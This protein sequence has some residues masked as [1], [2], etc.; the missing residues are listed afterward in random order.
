[1]YRIGDIVNNIIVVTLY[2]DRWYLDLMWE[3]F[4][5]YENIKSPWC[6]PET[7]RILYVNYTSKNSIS[8][9]CKKKNIFLK[10]A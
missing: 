7:N 6:I 9:P 3:H 2:G 10:E 8:S 1:M 4:I 5:I